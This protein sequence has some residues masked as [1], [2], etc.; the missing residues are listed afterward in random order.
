MKKSTLLNICYNCDIINGDLKLEER[1]NIIKRFA[2]DVQ[3]LICTDSAGESL[4]MQFA[5]IIVNYDMPWNPMIVE[6]R[7]GRV[8]RIGQ[9]FVVSALNLLLDNSIDERVYDVI[10][11]K[12]NKILHEI[13]IDKTADVL[14]STIEHK[15]IEKLYLTSLLNPE[16]FEA[17]SEN[18]LEQI[19]AKL[20]DYKS[21]EGALPIVPD[22]EIKKE[23]VEIIRHSPLPAWIE[24]LAKNYLTTK[25]ITYQPL[26]QGL[27][28][29][30]PG[31]PENE[32][33][34]NIKESLENPT[35]EPLSLQHDIIR[36][37]M[38]DAV[39]FTESQPIPIITINEKGFKPN[40]WWCLWSLQV[41]NQFDS[42]WYYSPIFIN[43]NGEVFQSTA[44]DLWSLL[45]NDTKLFS[46]IGSLS[47][48][49]SKREFSKL[50]TSAESLLQAKYID[51]EKK[52]M[53]NT[54]K[55]KSNKEKAFA[56]QEKQ[57]QKVGI[58]NIR[59][60]RLNKLNKDKIQWQDNFDSSSAIVPDLTCL[61]MVKI[62]NG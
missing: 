34:F 59:K 54:L 26:I 18:W 33:T 2:K 11:D 8:D 19:K 53:G 52:V 14:D 23:K 62:T 61:L 22:A 24:S 39:P 6:Q 25:G 7:I 35:L 15:S 31:F 38:E 56:F 32:Y 47:I 37:M 46:C 20:N 27:K 4:N 55:I 21:T 36:T 1:I 57:L 42:E 44:N 58:E 48:E 51:M 41:K 60:S 12:L 17:E 49:E 29:A 10:E 30:F 50:S 5:H 13:G 9:K 3:V 40:G 43:D 28:F 45:I 16:K